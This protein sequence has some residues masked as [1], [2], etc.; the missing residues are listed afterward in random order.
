MNRADWYD[1]AVVSVGNPAEAAR[2]ILALNVPRNALWTGFG[3]VVVLNTMILALSNLLLTGASPFPAMLTYPP[4][5]LVL[6]GSVLLL[7]IYAMFW[8]GRLMGGKSTWE[9]IMVLVIWLQALRVVV[10]MVT[11]VLVLT[12]PLLSLLLGISAFLVGLYMLVHFINQA[13]QFDSLGRSA[14]VLIG[15]S[16]AIAFGLSLLITLY[17]GPMIGT[18]LDV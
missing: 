7:S 2:R 11:F 4:V 16:L 3:L 5:Y 1:L 14:S 9:N 6:S 15:A 10:Q 12:I 18:P 13:H 8:I 17:G